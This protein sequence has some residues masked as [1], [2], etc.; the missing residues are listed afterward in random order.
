MASIFL[1][2]GHGRSTDGSWDCGCTNGDYTEADL[3]FNIIGKT[4][5]ILRAHG[6]SVYSDWDTGN[7]S[8]ITYCV[9]DAND[10]D[11]DI[12]ISGHCDFTGNT[13]G[14]LFPVLLTE[15]GKAIYDH[16]AAAAEQYSPLK[17]R[18]AGGGNYI[19]W[20]DDMEVE[21]TNMPACILEHGSIGCDLDLLVNRADDIA[22]ADAVGILNYFGISYNG[23][24]HTPSP[25]PE[26]S[27]PYGFTSAYN[28]SYY[29]SYGDGPD[30]NIGQMQ[31]DANFCGYRDENGNKLD[32]DDLFGSNCVY[33]TQCIE[34][35]HG[36]VV[37]SGYFGPDCDIELMCEVASIQE[38][39]NKHGYNL[40]VDG[41]V[42]D[43]TEAALADFQ[44]KNGLEVD[45][46][47]GDATR[48]LL[49]I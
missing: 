7:D 49:G 2:V 38:A 41:V 24:T 22:L 34:R 45:I 26:P 12:Y 14:G 23:N 31:R 13:V 17:P 42:G 3:M 4:V 16:V 27:N 25:A 35:F 48:A 36:L 46:S 21:K 19:I 39:L 18:K 30:P 40:T 8:N 5:A 9:Q 15:A 37:D 33:I 29:L 32:V 20:R 11:V 6:V 47:C 44:A 28:S 43:A 10:L 1:A